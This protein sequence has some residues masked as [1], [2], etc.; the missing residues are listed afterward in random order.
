MPQDEYI[1]TL[2]PPTA[3][4]GLHVG[5]MSGPFLAA[6][7]FYKY[8][9]LAGHRCVVTSY[10]DVNQSY[11]RVTAE[12]QKRD[13]RE[14]ARH[15]TQD[16][17]ETLEIFGSNVDE[18]YYPDETSEAFVRETFLR[19]FRDRIIRKKEMPVFYSL[20][21]DEYLD[22][23]GVAGYCP[24]CLAGCKWGICEACAYVNDATTLV[25]PRDTITGSDALEIRNIEVLVFEMEL[26][27]PALI[28]FYETNRSF[29][30]RYLELIRTAVAQPLPDFPISVPGEWGIPLNHAELPGQVINAWAE[31]MAHLVWCYGRAGT[32]SDHGRI[33]NFFGFDNS[34]FYGIVHVALLIA[35][36]Q[37]RWLPHATI[38]NE[39][40]NLEHKKFSTSSN[41]VVWARDLALRHT[42]D[43]IRFYAAFN[44]PGF[45]KANFS[46]AGMVSVLRTELIEPWHAIVDEVFS[47][48][49]ANEGAV[50]LATPEIV[51]LGRAA[52]SRIG[53]SYTL[54]HFHLRQAAEDI[55]HLLA[56]L[57]ERLSQQ[58]LPVADAVY[59]VKCFAQAAY[60]IIP[61]A[62]GELYRLVSGR[63]LDVFDLSPAV[64]VK[65][66]P[67]SIFERESLIAADAA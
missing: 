27:R 11:V 26:F 34:Y 48:I 52:L 37:Q 65:P 1:I 40:Y 21:R 36:G 15:W 59:L 58:R 22:E 5:H 56:F 33:V 32:S 9:R 17:R 3:N 64:I 2:P 6:D 4:G 31:V 60:P 13:P 42:T 12:R 25:S 38:N 39:F 49:G 50:A 7:V 24:R 28:N 10:S 18:F 47:Q 19:L 43:A 45:E 61:L 16:I 62:G 67:R 29:R 63:Q 51:A 53:A 35:S 8:H 57:R 41:H 14:L 55:L 23:A 66:L 20:E 44:N 30:P 54:G 46:E